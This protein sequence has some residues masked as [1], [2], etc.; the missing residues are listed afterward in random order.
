MHLHLRIANN[1]ECPPCQ[2]L[3][4]GAG[5]Q[6]QQLILMPLVPHPLQ[7][8]LVARIADTIALGSELTDLAASTEL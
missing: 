6:S 8:V 7:P 3:E 4:E 2:V 5:T 1:P